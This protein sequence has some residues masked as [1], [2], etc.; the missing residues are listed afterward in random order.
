M[1]R[2][3]W[4]TILSFSLSW[5]SYSE[6]SRALTAALF[7]ALRLSDWQR[8]FAFI[9]AFLYG[10][11]VPW[12]N[13]LTHN[14][15]RS[16]DVLS[17]LQASVATLLSLPSA[18]IAILCST[19]FVF[20]AWLLSFCFSA[21]RRST[22]LCE[23]SSSLNNIDVEILHALQTIMIPT[24]SHWPP[25]YLALADHSQA[26][27]KL[28]GG[29]HDQTKTIFI[30]LSVL[31]RDIVAGDV[32]LRNAKRDFPRLLMSTRRRGGGVDVDVRGEERKVR[33][34]VR[35][36]VKLEVDTTFWEEVA[37]WVLWRGGVSDPGWGFDVSVL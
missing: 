28:F 22:N 35:V 21:S 20:F 7:R 8:L 12:L 14:T 5:T 37:W 26:R 29:A 1:H 24:T 19:L 2:A 33:V 27:V 9:Q 16:L 3:P 34:R 23:L 15:L 4:A 30:P 18:G 10:H 32:E 36:R 17:W 25:H 11:L 31:I 13:Q 6:Y